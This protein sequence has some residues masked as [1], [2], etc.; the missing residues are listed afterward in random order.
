M[1]SALG[2]HLDEEIAEKYSL[3][4]MSARRVAEIEKHLLVCEPCRRA[5][6]ASDAYVAAM[7]VSAAKLRNGDRKTRRKVVGK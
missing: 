2:R 4:N 7:R 3:G 6:T 1:A 5:V